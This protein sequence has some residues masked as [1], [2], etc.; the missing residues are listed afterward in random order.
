MQPRRRVSYRLPMTRRRQVK[1]IVLSVLA[2]GSVTVAAAGCSTFTLTPSL[3][4]QLH[5]NLAYMVESAQ[6]DLWEYRDQLA[7]DP[8]GT[9]AGIGFVS[10]ARPAFEDPVNEVGGGTYILLG[11]SSSPEET[12][13]VLATSAGAS[14]GG[15]W[16][17]QSRTAAVCFTLRFPQA[18]SAIHTDSSDCTDGRGNSLSDL[19][20]AERYGEP[21]P[22]DGLDVRRTVTDADFKPLPCQC[23]SGGD[24]NCPGG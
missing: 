10:D 12:T 14:S 19:P 7:R 1:R 15:G 5:D 23:H 16:F 13:L 4:G 18:E 8:E 11:L 9:L 20:E 22:L 6:D 17:Y 3:E 24:C 2:C 21:I